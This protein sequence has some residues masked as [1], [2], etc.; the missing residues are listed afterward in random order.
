MPMLPTRAH[1]D[2][3]LGSEDGAPMGVP[4]SWSMGTTSK[5]EVG[6]QGS[7]RSRRCGQ[8]PGPH[9]PGGDPL[10]V[11]LDPKGDGRTALSVPATWLAVP[12][13]LSFFI[14]QMGL[15]ARLGALVQGQPETM[16][17]FMVSA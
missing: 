17:T 2:C 5:I 10:H 11:W 12:R 3:P 8:H 4:D 7:T 13:S 6:A 16:S 9:G 1:G 14:C 15:N